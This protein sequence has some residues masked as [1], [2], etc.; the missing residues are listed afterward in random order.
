M[1]EYSLITDGRNN[2]D[3]TEEAKND[4]IIRAQNGY[5][6]IYEVIETD[7]DGYVTSYQDIGLDVT[8]SS[9]F[10]SSSIE[11]RV[12]DIEYYTVSFYDGTD[13]M[14]TPQEQVILKGEKATRPSEV[15]QKKNYEFDNWMTGETSDEEFDFDNT[16]IQTTT[17]VY[18]SWKQLDGN[19][20][21]EYYLQNIENDGYPQDPYASEV[22]DGKAGNKVSLTQKQFSGFTIVPVE[23]ENLPTVSSTETIAVKYYYT[24][25]QYRLTWDANGGEI[26]DTDYTTGLIKY[27]ASIE[28]PTNLTRTGYVFEGWDATVV[29]TM[30][31]EELVYTA[32]WGLQATPAPTVA[33]TPV[34]TAEPTVAP[35]TAPTAVP[36]IAPT[37]APADKP[38]VMHAEIR[39]KGNGIQKLEWEKVKGADGYIIYYSSCSHKLKKLTTIA[40]GTVTSYIKKNCKDNQFYKYQVKAYKLVN[41]KKKII[42]K[43]WVCHGI[44][45]NKDSKYTNV[46]AVKVKNKSITVQVGKTVAYNKKEV[47]FIKKNPNKILASEKHCDR[48]R[49]RSS[50]SSIAKVKNGKIVGKKVGKCTLYV[51]APSG[52]CARVQII[53]KK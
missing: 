6:D 21:E 7:A 14:L 31:S 36:T 43:S 41:G 34:P 11:C 8:L 53:V 28:A 17:N 15:P 49:L 44:N 42:A 2:Y 48:I 40:D 20:K 32:Q 38:A 4:G 16:V 51:I 25:N 12:V 13:P 50:D 52:K 46:K 26:Q 23:E 3:H 19:Y 27:G 35:T 33:P 37:K 10:V 1:S 39:P 47:T 45:V 9:T 18:A 5:Y 22:I 24:R 29:E 30:P